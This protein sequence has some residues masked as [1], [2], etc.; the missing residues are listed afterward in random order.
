MMGEG[1]DILGLML[2]SH[3]VYQDKYHLRGYDDVLG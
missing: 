2:G 3:H 1:Y